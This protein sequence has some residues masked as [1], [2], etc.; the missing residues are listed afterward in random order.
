[1]GLLGRIIAAI[2]AAVPQSTFCLWTNGTLLPADCSAFS[3]FSHVHV[4]DYARDGHPPRNMTALHA[5][6][7]RVQVHSGILDT[8]LEDRHRDGDAPCLRPF[9]EFIVDHFGNVHLC[10][11]DWRGEAT[12]GNVLTDKLR[13]IVF[14]FQAAR[15]AMAGERMAGTAPAAC[16][17]CALRTGNLSR[18]VDESYRAAAEY[19]A[20]LR[21][22]P[23]PVAKPGHPN[24]GKPAVV[25]VFWRNPQ[26]EH[27]LPLQRLA[28]HFAWND[29]LYRQS[30]V[31]VYVVTDQPY[32]VP[33]YAE[34]VVYPAGRMP[35]VDGKLKF[36]LARTKNHGI[37][38]AIAAVHDPV[39]V[40]DPDIT[41]TEDAWRAALAVTE[42]IAS[43]PVYWLAYRHADRKCIC[44]KRNSLEHAQT[45]RKTH[46]DRGATG[47]ITMTAANW[48]RVKYDE[49]SWGYGAEDGLIL[50]DIQARRLN[51]V[52][53]EMVYHMAHDPTQPQVNFSG[54]DGFVRRDAWDA[55]SNPINFEGNRKLFKG[56]A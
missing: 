26:S 15:Q 22:T 24:A 6:C 18:F 39:I 54:A 17:R 10:C 47:T 35:M 25:F 27:P 44:R 31:R 19:V 41:W 37:A 13:D 53:N 43:I 1:M 32:D 50:R 46:E 23:A 28:D 21:K 2:R 14:R 56:R 36:S 5:A 4:T 7:P 3:V 11:Y 8:R 16:R 42:Q 29:R 9:T 33:E 34:C 52:R 12:M 45:C 49:R 40:T 38:H 48:W 20:A 51:V 30:S 55:E